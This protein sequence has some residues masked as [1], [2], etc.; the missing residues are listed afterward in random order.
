MRIEISK[1]VLAAI[2]LAALAAIL[3]APRAVPDAVRVGWLLK[4]TRQALQ[5]ARA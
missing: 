4:A 3:F 1:G 5:E 2:A